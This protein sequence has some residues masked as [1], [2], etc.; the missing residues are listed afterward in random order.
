[1]NL[2]RHTPLLI[3][4][5]LAE[6]LAS[7]QSAWALPPD[8]P[9]PKRSGVQ[10]EMAPS[11]GEEINGLGVD[12]VSSSPRWELGTVMR[13]SVT[14]M[15]VSSRPFMV[16]V[17]GELGES[18]ESWV[19]GGY[20]VTP[21]SLTWTTVTKSP[22]LGPSQ[23]FVK[24]GRRWLPDQFVRLEPGGTYTKP[25]S[26]VLKNFPTGKFTITVT[27]SAIGTAASWKDE[28]G[29][30]SGSIWTG[31]AISKPLTIEVIESP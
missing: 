6:Y 29:F 13:F 15:N 7:P 23:A 28:A 10:H 1:M 17:F 2:S 22:V 26:Y 27:Y 25:L 21:W 9:N 31:M 18:Y 16:D 19:G 30:P 24:G 11:P 20:A 14:L 4:A 5:L 3:M 8:L 12:V